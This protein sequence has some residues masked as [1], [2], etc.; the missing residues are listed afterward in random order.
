MTDSRMMTPPAAPEAAPA[1]LAEA[2]KQA[3]SLL[4]VGLTQEEVADHLRKQ[5]L[6]PDVVNRVVKR[7]AGSAML[8][9]KPAPEEPE[10][11]KDMIKG[12]LWMG[13]GLLVTVI[14]YLAAGPHGTYVVTWGAMLFGAIKFLRGLRK[15]I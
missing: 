12:G 2:R 3:A 10:G 15:G 6:A 9:R 5:G 1:E 4:A 14:S 7:T 11:R 8:A 13:G